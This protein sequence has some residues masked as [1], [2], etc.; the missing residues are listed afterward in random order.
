MKE[1]KQ[2]KQTLNWVE[3]SKPSTNT[4]MSKKVPF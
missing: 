1:K 3:T 2:K 4:V